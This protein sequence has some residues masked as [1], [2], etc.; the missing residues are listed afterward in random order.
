[1]EYDRDDIYY[2]RVNNFKDN[3]LPK[4]KNLLC[5]LVRQ[6]IVY[7]C[8]YILPCNIVSSSPVHA[9]RRFSIHKG[10]TNRKCKCIPAWT[11][12]YSGHRLPIVY[13]DIPWNRDVHLSERVRISWC[14]V[15]RSAT[16]MALVMLPCDLPWWPA[17]VKQLDRAAAARNSD[18][19]LEAMQR[20]HDMCKWVFLLLLLLL[21]LSRTI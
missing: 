2:H 20:L 14:S 1:M 4:N 13:L 10:R 18:D 5:N 19:L 15:F 21:L 12:L 17:V 9:Y 7:M 11:C 8:M 6:T 16:N 3:W